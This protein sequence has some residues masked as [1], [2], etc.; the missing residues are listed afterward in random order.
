MIQFEK[1][2]YRP[3]IH[4]AL[5]ASRYHVPP[6]LIRTVLLSLSHASGAHIYLFYKKNAE[7]KEAFQSHPVLLLLP[8]SPIPRL[9]H[10]PSTHTLH[11]QRPQPL[12]EQT[13]RR[14]RAP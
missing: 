10:L 6:F 8:T 2:G 14:G 13:L 11:P 5:R 4:K 9:L 12:R 3:L 7:P 1:V